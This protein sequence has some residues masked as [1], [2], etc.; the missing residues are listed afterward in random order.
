M[1]PER[2][3]RATLD[4]AAANVLTMR[5]FISAANCYF[6]NSNAFH[7]V[8]V[9]H[10][11]ASLLPLACHTALGTGATASDGGGPQQ[12]TPAAGSDEAGYGDRPAGCHD[13][14]GRVQSRGVP[15]PGQPQEQQLDGGDD[16]AGCGEG[17][18]AQQASDAA[19]IF[20]AHA[21]AHGPPVAVEGLPMA[22]GGPDIAAGEAEAAVVVNMQEYQF[23][24]PLEAYE[25]FAKAP[26]PGVHRQAVRVCGR[27]DTGQLRAF[28]V[29]V[30]YR[31]KDNRTVSGVAKLRRWV[32]I[33]DSGSI[34]LSRCRIPPGHVEDQ[35]EEEL[36][37]MVEP[38]GE[39][40][41]EAAATGRRGRH[42]APS[43]KGAA[44]DPGRKLPRSCRVPAAVMA[45]RA[46]EGAEPKGTEAAATGRRG[47][48]VVSSGEGA[49]GGAG[50]GT[51]A[52]ALARSG[53]PAPK[54]GAQVQQEQG[55]VRPQQQAPDSEPEDTLEDVPFSKRQRLEGA[56]G[57]GGVCGSA[58]AASIQGQGQD[59]GACVSYQLPAGPPSALA[60]G[61]LPAPKPE[62]ALA[63]TG[64]APARTPAAGSSACPEPVQGLNLAPGG[65]S[66]APQ[67]AAPAASGLG[68]SPAGTCVAP[69][70]GAAHGQHQPPAQQTPLP[71]P[72]QLSEHQEQGQQRVVVVANPDHLP[73]ASLTAA[74]LYRA[75]PPAIG[76][77]PL[78][79]GELRL[80]GFTFHPH[81]APGVRRAMDA[82]TEGLGGRA[83]EELD[84]STEQ[85]QV[86]GV[87]LGAG[88]GLGAA[89]AGAA[90]AAG[91]GEAQVSAAVQSS[92]AL[93][94]RYK[95]SPAVLAARVAKLVGLADVEAW[96]RALSEEAP[97][98][99]DKLERRRDEQ[100]GGWGLWA[101]AA[102]KKS[103]PLGVVG[104][105]VMPAG[106]GSRFVAS[107]LRHCPEEVRGELRGRV[108]NGSEN[109]DDDLATRLSYGWKMLA[110]SYCTPYLGDRRGAAGGGPRSSRVPCRAT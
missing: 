18:G 53:E 95:L 104:G 4:N 28:S 43:G 1:S 78:Q 91:G 10:C 103:H 33:E 67:P 25:W 58:R 83:L 42:D 21:A 93:I 2:C 61:P 63:L 105:Y 110:A 5:T 86:L 87:G 19:A 85:V 101:K 73:A 68:G 109:D 7:L 107:G 13:G 62:P 22:S 80:C 64:P 90:A 15:Q 14:Q 36:T 66:A 76:P 54:A 108:R 98:Q 6:Y 24:L 70:D 34:R 3:Y 56:H 45:E 96:G 81:L 27:S 77:P 89:A 55:S 106:V 46:G 94:Q 92:A 74:H 12:Q 100:R 60:P 69:Q 35:G 48:R 31:G 26:G 49:A 11:N 20:A 38:A 39:E 47:R 37:V 17:P 29:N 51:A 88:K 102:V 84:P 79:P 75:V 50:Q 30:F 41:D 97:V 32:G 8:I 65:A 59:H 40:E 44:G 52:P 82:W 9:L 57:E 99:G 71:P 72:S 16:P 23:S